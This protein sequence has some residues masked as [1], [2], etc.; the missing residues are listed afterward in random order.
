MAASAEQRLSGG[1]SHPMPVATPPPP[2][3]D[4]LTFIGNATTLLRHAGFTILTD[5]NFLRRG[6]FAYLG[7]VHLSRRRKDPALGIEQLPALDAVVLSHLHG[8]HWD[9]WLGEACP[10]ALP[11]VTTRHAASR[12]RRQG[13]GEATAWATWESHKP[14]K[15]DALLRITAMPG[16]HGLGRSR[17]LA[18]PPVMGSLLEFVA[19][20]SDRQL[21]IFLTVTRSP[22][23]GWRTSA[24]DT[25]TSTSRWSTSV[26][27]GYSACSSPR[28]H[29]G[30]SRP[31]MGGPDPLCRPWGDH[32]ASRLIFGNPYRYNPVPPSSSRSEATA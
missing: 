12:L 1:T 19:T 25:R 16:Q 28:V 10:G 4:G 26:A 18:P 31:G 3:V 11:I 21:R 6:Q 23:T 22:T 32:A 5:P 17:L 13:F 20:P 24:S 7:R 30:C 14:R 15:G 29:R 9:R 2:P 8:D 27:C